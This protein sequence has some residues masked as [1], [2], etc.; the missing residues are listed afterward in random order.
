M[1]IKVAPGARDERLDCLKEYAKANNPFEYSFRDCHK[2][3]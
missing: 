3:R 1:P 2:I